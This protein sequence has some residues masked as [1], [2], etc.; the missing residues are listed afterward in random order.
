M[1]LDEMKTAWKELDRRLDRQQTLSEAFIRESIAARS[2]RSAN[3]FLTSEMIGTGLLLLG[4]P[5]VVH[6]YGMPWA[7]EIPGMKIVLIA[8]IVLFLLLIVWQLIKIRPLFKIDMSKGVSD[9][10]NYVKKYELYTLYEKRVAIAFIP[11]LI[12]A[13]IVWRALAVKNAPWYWALLA[14]I[15]IIC[16]LYC[17][18]YYKKFYA[19]NMRTIKHGISVKAPESSPTRR[20]VQAED[21]PDLPTSD[22]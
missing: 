16:A 2:Q 21:R 12:I 18:W 3:K 4:I 1:E 11:L 9:N 22:C 6:Q 19:T 8:A 14:G 10:I 15:V 7:G 17:V 20:H 13:G 5:F